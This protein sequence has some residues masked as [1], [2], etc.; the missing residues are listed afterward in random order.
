MESDSRG[1]AVFSCTSIGNG[2]NEIVLEFANDLY[3]N[4]VDSIEDHLENIP[5]TIRHHVASCFHTGKSEEF[6]INLKANGLYYRVKAKVVKSDELIICYLFDDQKVFDRPTFASKMLE[7]TQDLVAVVDNNYR[8]ILFNAPYRREIKQVYGVEMSPGMTLLEAVAHNQKDYESALPAWQQAFKGIETRAEGTFGNLRKVIYEYHFNPIKDSDGQVR[9]AVLTVRNINKFRQLEE[10]SEDRGRLQNLLN[11]SPDVILKIDSSL[12]CQYVNGSVKRF[13][14][15]YGKIIGKSFYDLNISEPVRKKLE[16]YFE[17]VFKGKRVEIFDSFVIRKNDYDLHIIFIPQVNDDGDVE[18]AIIVCH[19]LTSLNTLKQKFKAIFDGTFQFIGLID[20]D[21]KIMEAN[22]TALDFAGITIE[23]IA[24]SY[25]WETPWFFGEVINFIKDSVQRA[26]AGEFVRQNIPIQDKDGNKIIIDFSLKPVRNDKGEVIWLLPEG[27]DISELIK[28][29]EKLEEIAEFTFMADN[30]PIIIWTANPDG[31]V[32]YVNE[33]FFKY[34]GVTG[35]ELKKGRLGELLLHPKELKVI[36][37]T[38]KEAVR[39]Q[40]AVTMEHRVRNQSGSY[41]WYI[42]K[43]SPM[44]DQ[45]G[46]LVKW[47]GTAVDIDKLKRTSLALN[48]MNRHLQELTD[49]MP[50]IVWTGDK[51]GVTDFFN[52]RWVDYTG[53][54]VSKSVKHGWMDIVHPDDLHN[55]QKIWSDK[56]KARREFHLEYRLRGK[57]GFYRWFLEEG[58]PYYDEEGNLIKW[59]GT[60]TDIQDQHEASKQLALKAEE[61]QTMAETI[62]QVVWTAN[63][64]GELTFLSHKW[65]EWTGMDI[66]EGLDNGWMA[67]IHKD[68]RSR[69]KKKFEECLKQQIPF[70]SEFR[71]CDNHGATF[72]VLGLGSPS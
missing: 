69:V 14:I 62:P 1:I 28:A 47:H 42:S 59:V 12:T 10:D 25:I 13:G 44:M 70:F 46:N 19:D 55:S 32:Q 65:Q 22:K 23:E 48:S 68:D 35:E 6:D 53:M 21:G 37:D 64:R 63:S 60:A 51:D 18:S 58:R 66:L 20:K 2:D 15:N 61:F 27:R 11:Q 38:W 41:C 72:W 40:Q 3:S 49:A 17:A 5:V 56:I 16:P 4:I 52:K 29:E 26:A 30:L 50:V 31:E 8:F 24:G 34:T 43:I 54:E 33:T 45:H 71:L 57:D 7:H 9:S 67:C 39:N 36:R